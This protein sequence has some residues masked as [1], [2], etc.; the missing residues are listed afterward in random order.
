ML[1][2]ANL[3][4]SVLATA[5]AFPFDEGTI[6]LALLPFFHIAGM[7]CVLHTVLYEGGTAVLMRRFESESFLRAIQKYRIEL[8]SLVPPIVVVLAKHAAVES[9][10]LSSLRLVKG[11][12]RTQG[13]T[14]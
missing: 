5:T 9:Y 13:P 1:T 2:H 3:V 7:V 8:A 6:G 11:C 12:C 14:L 4:A 10:D